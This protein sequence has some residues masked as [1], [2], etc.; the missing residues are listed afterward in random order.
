MPI[1]TIRNDAPAIKVRNVDVPNVRSRFSTILSAG[2]LAANFAGAGYLIGMLGLTY[3]KVQT[4]PATP[5][6][7]KSD[8]ILVVRIRN[9]D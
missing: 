8:D 5:A 4:V 2:S 6:S 9:T 3:S 1:A 7:F